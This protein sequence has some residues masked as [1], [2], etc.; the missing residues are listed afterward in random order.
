MNHFQPAETIRIRVQQAQADLYTE[1][2]IL[3]M[4]LRTQVETAVA[5]KQFSIQID[6]GMSPFCVK[7]A[8]QLLTSYGYKV[9]YVTEKGLSF[10]WE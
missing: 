10:S 2:E 3:L 7:F 6:I 9:D 1:P 5:N 4:E 8:Q